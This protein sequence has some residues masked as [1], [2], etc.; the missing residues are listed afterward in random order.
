MGIKQLGMEWDSAL[1]FAEPFAPIITGDSLGMKGDQ[2]DRPDVL[3]GPGCS[4]PL[5]NV[6]NPLDYIKTQCFA[7]PDPTTRFGD[8]WRSILIGPAFSTW[9]HRYFAT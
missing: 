5:V 6:G 8:A 7:F 4:G 3:S 9:I 1:A 2:F